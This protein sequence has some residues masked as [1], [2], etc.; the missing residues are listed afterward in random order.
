MPDDEAGHERHRGRDHQRGQHHVEDRLGEPVGDPGQRV[1]RQRADQQR[2]ERG[3]HGDDR[4][5]LHR[6]QH[7]DV[8]VGE[9][10]RDVGPLRVLRAKRPGPGDVLA[11]GQ[12]VADQ[13]VERQQERH[14][15][16]DQHHPAGDV[17]DP[18]A[19]RSLALGVLRSA[20]LVV[21]MSRLAMSVLRSVEAEDPALDDGDDGDDRRQDQGARAAQPEVL[22]GAEGEVVEVD[23]RWPGVLHVADAGCRTRRSAW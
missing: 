7:R 23:Q 6:R 18:A 15:H 12:P 14:R 4:R 11:G 13:Q 21:R 20:R 8:G 9:Q 19:D 16:Q 17:G 1:G 10:R 2:A 5:V 22:L 3:E